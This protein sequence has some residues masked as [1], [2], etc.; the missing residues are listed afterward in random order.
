MAGESQKEKQSLWGERRGRPWLAAGGRGGGSQGGPMVGSL[1]G[2]L[3]SVLQRSGWKAVGP[4]RDPPR[5]PGHRWTKGVAAVRRAAPGLPPAAVCLPH[6]RN[7]AQ[8]L[9]VRS[10]EARPARQSTFSTLPMTFSSK[11]GSTAPSSR[12]SSNTTPHSNSSLTFLK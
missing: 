7:P 11:T 8:A 4:Q 10:A 1:L 3:L 12:T 6:S 5:P 9:V 2:G